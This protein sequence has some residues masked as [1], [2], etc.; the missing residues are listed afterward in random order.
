MKI[1]QYWLF[2]KPA[3]ITISTLALATTEKNNFG[4]F[5]KSNLEN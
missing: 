2:P 3:V 1:V 4:K 5:D